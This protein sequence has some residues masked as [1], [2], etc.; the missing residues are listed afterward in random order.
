[1]NFIL[2]AIKAWGVYFTCGNKPII[3][4]PNNI[5]CIPKAKSSVVPEKY[6]KNTYYEPIMCAVGAEVCATEGRFVCDGK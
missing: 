4:N 6:L 3:Y 1:L 5:Q 2:I